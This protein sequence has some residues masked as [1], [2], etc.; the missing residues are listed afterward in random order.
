MEIKNIF[1][2]EQSDR[3][4]VWSCSS[5]SSFTA[6]CD[7]LSTASNYSEN[8]SVFFSKNSENR[9]AIFLIFIVFL[10]IF[11]KIDLTLFTHMLF[12]LFFDHL[13]MHKPFIFSNISFSAGVFG[14]LSRSF[15]SHSVIPDKINV[16][17]YTTSN[18]KTSNA[19]YTFTKPSVIPSIRNASLEDS[20]VNLHGDKENCSPL[21]EKQSRPMLQSESFKEGNGWVASSNLHPHLA[22]K[23]S[24][25]M[26]YIKMGS[27]EKTQNSVKTSV[28][29]TS[30]LN[31]KDDS[32]ISSNEHTAIENPPF[33]L[34]L[35]KKFKTPK[36]YSQG[37]LTLSEQTAS[38]SVNDSRLTQSF[39]ENKSELTEKR[40]VYKKLPKFFSFNNSRSKEDPVNKTYSAILEIEDKTRTSIAHF[41]AGGR[42]NDFVNKDEKESHGL[43][44]VNVSH[45]EDTSTSFKPKTDYND[46]ICNDS[47]LHRILQIK[48]IKV[49]FPSNSRI[50]FAKEYL[51]LTT[52][53]TKCTFHL[54]SNGEIFNNFSIS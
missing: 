49:S 41:R 34:S 50:V 53:E 48:D 45:N 38:T 39:G 54:K 6:S 16:R 7:E 43:S 27:T 44:L 5:E 22:H 13:T 25:S 35:K 32:D 9:S 11:L 1:Q 23:R 21:K 46:N 24:L 42:Q 30:F 36:V 51:E 2:D 14:A 52:E 33:K 29:V 20:F 18:L 8:R 26:E 31:K 10:I 37:D 12:L 17:R 28:K 40:R 19:E 47:S 3:L 15:S 4:S